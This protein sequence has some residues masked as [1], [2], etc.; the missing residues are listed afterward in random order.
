MGEILSSVYVIKHTL[1]YFYNLGASNY[2]IAALST[3]RTLCKQ[4]LESQA[5]CAYRL[6]CRTL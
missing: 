1:L 6:G 3:S 4:S 2:A 5:E